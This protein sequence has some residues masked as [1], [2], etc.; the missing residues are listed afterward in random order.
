MST[1]RRT[2]LSAPWLPT[3]LSLVAAALVVLIAVPVDFRRDM[4]VLGAV[5]SLLALGM[6]LPFV[7]GDG[8]SLAYNAYLGIGAFS[9][10]LLGKHTEWS[11]LWGVPI[12]AVV[13]ALVALILGLATA[14]LSGF[15]LAGVTLLFGTCFGTLL[16]RSEEVTGG[17]AGIPAIPAPVFLGHELDRMDVTLLAV[18][19]AW[20]TAYAL[21]RLRRSPYGVVLRTQA[22][23]PAVV[24][25]S[26]ISAPVV[27]L[28]SLCMGAAIA[29]LGGC[30]LAMMSRQVVPDTFGLSIVFLAVFMP[31]L[32]GKQSPWG[33]V[34]G[35]VIVVVLV[36][37][38]ALFQEAGSLVF[39]VCVLLVLRFAPNGVLGIVGGALALAPRLVRGTARD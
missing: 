17:A 5:Y 37:D 33:S 3:A 28:L 13:S 9:V 14:R 21:T 22:E 26:G 4:V 24:E 20:V 31:L 16:L 38:F 29:S 10:A 6:Y 36:F 39:A 32:G 8:L 19:T 7:M 27:K 15:Y 23:H 1:Q 12:A 18:G 30:L 25:A 2:P 34:L 11:V 35:A